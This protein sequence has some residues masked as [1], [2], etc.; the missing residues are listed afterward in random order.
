MYIFE[1]Q[2]MKPPF[3]VRETT[4]KADSGSS[5]MSTLNRSPISL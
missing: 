1:T 2:T 5:A 4:V 3:I